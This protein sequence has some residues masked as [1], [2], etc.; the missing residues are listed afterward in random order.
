MIN[1]MEPLKLWFKD[2][3]MILHNAHNIMVSKEKKKA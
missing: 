3:L 2:H 1:Y